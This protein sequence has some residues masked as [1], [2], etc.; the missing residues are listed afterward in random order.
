MSSR[1]LP[2]ETVSA[3]HPNLKLGPGLLQATSASSLNKDGILTTRA[4]WLNHSVNG[5]KW[6][7]EGN[8]RRVSEHFLMSWSQ[9]NVTNAIIQYVPAAQESVIGTVIAR[10]GE[11]WRVDVGAAQMANLDGL[12]FEGATKRNRPNLKVSPLSFNKSIL[13]TLTLN[14]S[15]LCCTHGYP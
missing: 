2:G 12:A 4:G 14:R 8:S 10:S 11:N 15:V 5:A 7:V 9:K 3:S 13:S 1:I 6:W